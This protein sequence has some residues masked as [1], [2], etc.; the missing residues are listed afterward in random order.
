MRECFS[1]VLSDILNIRWETGGGIMHCV[2]RG[3]IQ[4]SIQDFLTR[5][6]LFHYTSVNQERKLGDRRW[7]DTTVVPTVNY[8][9]RRLDDDTFLQ[10]LSESKGNRKSLGFGGSM[11]AR[12]KLKRID[13]R[14]HQKWSLRLNSTQHGKTYQDRIASRIDRLKSFHDFLYGGAWPFLVRGLICL[15]NSD[16]VRDLNIL[17]RQLLS[18]L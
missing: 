7:L 6:Q 16:N 2:A 14:T 4:R 10:I 18:L 15:V 1:M 5:R 3:E 17:F 11:V 9:N 13:G 12:L 8:T